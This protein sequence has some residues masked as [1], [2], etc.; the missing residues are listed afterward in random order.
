VPAADHNTLV[1]AET[2]S[3]PRKLADGV[4]HYELVY[5]RGKQIRA[6]GAEIDGGAGP[7]TLFP[8]EDVFFQAATRGGR[9]VDRIIEG[10]VQF[11]KNTRAT[12]DVLTAASG[13]SAVAGLSM[14]AGGGLAAGFHTV[15]AIGV[16][17]QG[18]SARSRTQADTRYWHRLPDGLHVTT[19]RLAPGAGPLQVRF[20]DATSQPLP[21][22][23]DT[24]AVHF[25]D[26]GNGLAFASSRPTPKGKPL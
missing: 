1:I 5:R 19:L 13:N 2:G 24:V 17:A 6:N 12:G 23:T 21:D 8:V 7:V 9:T 15:T 26:R 18:L 16:A 4:G 20:L 3:A 10:K 25:D 11:K 14:A 22:G